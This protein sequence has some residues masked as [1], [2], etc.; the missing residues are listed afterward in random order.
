MAYLLKLCG[1]FKTLWWIPH[2][3]RW[4]FAQISC[5]GRTQTVE[6]HDSSETLNDVSMVHSFL[7]I[8][9]NTLGF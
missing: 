4:S 2:G 7:S 5:V 8:L 6:G 9:S 1:I 3:S